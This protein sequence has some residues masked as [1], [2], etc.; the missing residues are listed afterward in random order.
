MMFVI[1][2]LSSLGDGGLAGSPAR[3]AAEIRSFMGIDVLSQRSGVPGFMKMAA[4]SARGRPGKK[5]IVY[6]L[7]SPGADNQAEFGADVEGD[8]MIEPSDQTMCG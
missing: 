2:R 1:R 4:R 5:L 3:I 6:E 7:A 8:N